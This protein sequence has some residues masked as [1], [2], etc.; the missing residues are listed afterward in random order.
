MTRTKGGGL[1]VETNREDSEGA[2]GGLGVDTGLTGMMVRGGYEMKTSVGFLVT[3]EKADDPRG[4]LLAK[5]RACKTAAQQQAFIEANKGRIKLKQTTTGSEA[6]SSSGAE[7]NVGP[8][9]LSLGSKGKLGRTKKTGADGGLLDS[10]VVGSQEVGGSA[11]IGEFLRASDSRTDTATSKR[12]GKGNV[13]LD[14]QRERKSS[15]LFAKVK[16]ALGI[17]DDEAEAKATGALEDIAGKAKPDTD[18]KTVHGMR[19]GKADIARIVDKAGDARA[20]SDLSWGVGDQNAI[21]QWSKLGRDIARVGTSDPAWVADELAAFV[22]ADKGRRMDVL[23][24]LVRPGGSVS[25]GKRSE[26]PKSLK[27]HAKAYD[28]LVLNGCAAAVEEKA[29]AEGPAAATAWGQQQFQRLEKMLLDVRQAAD[30]AR[31]RRRSR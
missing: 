1:E 14:L 26:F 25:V 11:G 12:D 24:R 29:A 10:E 28:E 18:E 7:F 4:E 13:S 5:F 27:A 22:G 6:G 17:G 3:I 8:A 31:T 16:G 19:L 21:L 23:M 9:D 2:S 20:W 30:S 15:N